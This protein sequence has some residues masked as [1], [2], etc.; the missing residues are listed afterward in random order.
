MNKDLLESGVRDRSST[1]YA[2]ENS[3]NM[4]EVTDDFFLKN[5]SQTRQT[6]ISATDFGD[7]CN[8]SQDNNYSG[9]RTPENRKDPKN[10]GA[11]LTVAVVGSGGWGGGSGGSPVL[12]AG[13]KASKQERSQIKDLKSIENT[14]MKLL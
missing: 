12:R 3:K 9:N 5:E 8:Q 4:F 7:F 10:L 14:K 6:K 1:V 13:R 2:K 11:D